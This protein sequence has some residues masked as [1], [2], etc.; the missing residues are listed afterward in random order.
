MGAT[1]KSNAEALS[2]VPGTAR[3]LLTAYTGNFAN[4]GQI[5]AS[6]WDRLMMK[7]SVQVSWVF[8]MLG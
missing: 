2:V 4:K 8:E 1:H 7:D 5:C 3:S 6:I